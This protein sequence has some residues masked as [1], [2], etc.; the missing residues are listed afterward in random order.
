MTYKAIKNF[1]AIIG[2]C[3]HEMYHIL[4]AILMYPFGTRVMGWE[5]KI[6]KEVIFSVTTT[7]KHHLCA[8]FVSTAPAIF[9]VIAILLPLLTL[10]PMMEF[11][12][13]PLHTECFLS[14]QD[15]ANIKASL[16]ALIDKQAHIATETMEFTPKQP[17]L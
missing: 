1:H 2:V 6:G 10:H 11:I 8:I 7:T 17:P 3:I 9:S 16:N 4:A 14:K 13:I 12:I 15:I 5:S